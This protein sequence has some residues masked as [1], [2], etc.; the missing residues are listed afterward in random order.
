MV[1]KAWWYVSVSSKYYSLECTEASILQTSLYTVKHGETFFPAI[2]PS[3][4]L[5]CWSGSR[6]TTYPATSV[7]FRHLRQAAGLH[8]ARL[9]SP[10]T[11]SMRS[12][13]E[14]KTS[15]PLR[16][17]P[18]AQRVSPSQRRTCSR[19]VAQSFRHPEAGFE[20]LF[21]ILESGL[22]SLW[23]G[24]G[25]STSDWPYS[26]PLITVDWSEMPS[27]CHYSVAAMAL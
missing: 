7:T 16:R 12:C 13:I 15:P 20:Y 5:F 3:R 25:M 9:R 1:E 19:L 4:N 27:A 24:I 17:L 21:L 22:V 18:H 10:L 14:R 11:L 23:T 26:I 2:F 6:S 8:G